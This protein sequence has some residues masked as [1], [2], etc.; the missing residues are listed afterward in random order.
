MKTAAAMF[1]QIAYGLFWFWSGAS[2]WLDPTAFSLAI[3]N[4]DLVG[5]P[6]VAAMALLIPPLECVAALAIIFHRGAAGG[7]ALLWSALLVFTLA[8]TISWARGL[9]IECGCFGLSGSTVNYP[10]KLLQNGA[11]LAVGGWLWWVEVFREQTSD[12]QK[13]SSE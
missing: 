6:W 5:D 2:K 4:F 9:D 1:L 8:I 7:L 3:R 13:V 12:E 11:L 10:M